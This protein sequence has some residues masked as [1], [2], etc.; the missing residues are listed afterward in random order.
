VPRPLSGK[1][2][3][4]ATVLEI[5]DRLE[6]AG[7]ETWCVGGAVRDA[8][9]GRSHLDWDLATAATPEEVRRVFGRRFTVP[10]GVEHG[11]VGVL[12]RFGG[13]HEVTTFRRDVRT[14]GRHAVVEFGASLDND[15]ARRDFTINAIAYHPRRHTL[16]DPY[17]GRDDLERGI[18]RAVG[19]PHARMQ[20]DRL[21]AL[22]AIRFAGRFGFAIDPATWSAILATAPQLRRLSAERV[23]QE[24]EKTMDQV[25]RP[26]A[27]L[28]LWQESGAMSVLVPRLANVDALTL[29]AVDCVPT[30]PGGVA[31]RRR[32]RRIARFAVLFSGLDGVAAGAALAS[33]RFSKSDAAAVAN[34]VDRWHA[35]APPMGRALEAGRPI[36]DGEVRRLVSEMG[37]LNVPLVMRVASALWSA[38]RGTST[39]APDPR[40]VRSLYRRLLRS[41][42]RDPL[43]LSDLAVDGD[44]LRRAGIPPGPALGKILEALLDR[45]I[46]DPSLNTPGWLV[47]EARRLYGTAAEGGGSPDTM[48]GR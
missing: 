32:A 7:Y 38:R 18:V 29:A 39:P 19:D 5:A 46:R 12:D 3:P 27:A 6:E 4:P 20:E 36:D 11:T 31:P 14:D 42:F 8:L 25:P 2:E 45:V 37:R 17:G 15:L 47:E 44:D 34:V 16:R 22:R 48:R 1:L 26:S 35:A 21:R 23:K 9:L 13:L 30:P 43:E 28:A 24:L 33:L 41:G 40:A 10:V